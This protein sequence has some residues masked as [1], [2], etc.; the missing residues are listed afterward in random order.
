VG[1]FTGGSA[2]LKGERR[3]RTI[4]LPRQILMYL[5]RQDLRLPLEEVGRLIGGRDHTTVLHAA[6]K[7][8]GEIEINHK[9]QSELSEVRKTIFSPGA[10]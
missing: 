8:R 1:I 4:A 2:A 5:L 6:D 3:T 7:V 10:D 9:F